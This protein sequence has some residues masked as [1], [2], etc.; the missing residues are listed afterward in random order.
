M[1]YRAVL[2][3][4]FLLLVGVAGLVWGDVIITVEGSVIQGTIEFGIPGIISLETASG[5][6]FTIK[7]ENIKSIRFAEEEGKGDTVETY[8][9][10]I[11]IGSIGGIPDVIG[12]RTASGDILSVKRS[13]IR[14]IRFEAAQA[15][16][17]PQPQ[18]GP[19]P[20]SVQA[21]IDDL[22]GLYKER[23]GS[24]ALGLDLFLAGQMV[25]NGFGYPLSSLGLSA[26][27]G[28]VWRGYS[29]P[30]AKRVEAVAEEAL[31]A[32]ATLSSDDLVEEVK[33]DLKKSSFFYFQLGTD[34]L[35]FPSVGV[36]LLF[37]LGDS[38]FID[39]G[40]LYNP[41]LMLFLPYLGVI[42]VF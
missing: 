3:A 25:R 6:I 30:P 22:V 23:I 11:L 32:N 15:Q 31:A 35:I 7:K 42:I 8:D 5:D 4:V 36:G 34:V 39:V 2:L 12:I 1:R 16:P 13:S 18:P 26:T 10:N 19:Q 24:F 33:K 14:E 21:A 9:G 29:I 20:V 27:L 17:Q 37:P 40:A 41:L 28:V 38:G